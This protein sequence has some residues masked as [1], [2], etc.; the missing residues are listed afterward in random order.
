[1]ATTPSSPMRF[2]NVAEARERARRT[3]PHSM[4]DYIVGGAQDEATLA[5]NE[6]AFRDVHFR[7]RM[8]VDVGTPRLETTVLGTAVSLPVLLAPC[9][10]VQTVHADGCAGVLRAAHAAGTIPVV[11]TFAG[12]APEAVAD[13]PGPRWFQLYAPDRATAGDLI[14]RASACGF[15]GLVITIDSPTAGN[16]ERDA[17]NNVTAALNLNLRTIAQFAP[18]VARRPRWMIR[19]LK[20]TLTTL[21]RTDVP[22]EASGAEREERAATAAGVAPTPTLDTERVSPFTWDDLARI[23]ADWQGRLLVKGVLTGEDAARAAEVGMD[24]VIVSNHGG[25]QLDGAPATLRVLPEVVEAAGGRV[26]VLVDGGVRRGGDVL[27]ALALGARAVLIGRPYMY[28]LA[29]GGQAGVEGV[30]S[31]LRSEMTRDMV[32]MG[33]ADVADLDETW[34]RAAR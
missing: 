34:V 21:A 17:R 8:A 4:F 12:V 9:G 2:I 13:E 31:V 5:A 28:G 18:Q 27:R 6:A 25:R 10:L 1:M 15:E 33:C 32:L 11:S 20:N 16:R 14:G 22:G 29:A 24:A 7:P 30:L 23:R 26:E 19:N 3:L